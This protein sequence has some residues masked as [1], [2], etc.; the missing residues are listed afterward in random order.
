MKQRKRIEWTRLENV[1]KYF[2]ATASYKDTKVFRFTCELYEAVEPNILQEALDITIENFP[3]YKSVLRRGVFW[4]YLESSDIRP[5][6]EIESKPVCAPIYIKDNRSLLF[7][8]F[9]YNNR[10][11]LEMFHVLSDG[12]GALWFMESLVHYYLVIKYKEK[13]KNNEPELNYSAAISEKMD[14]SF[15]RYFVGEDILK[16]KPRGKNKNKTNPAYQIKGTIMDENRMN[17]IE[18][19]MSAKAVLELAHEYNAT[20]T[21]FLTSLFLFSIYKDMPARRR[22][23]P[24]V[25]SVPINLRQFFKSSTSRNFFSTMNIGYDFGKDNVEF[26]SVIEC[27]RGSFKKELSEERLTRQLNQFIALEKNPFTRIVPLPLKDYVI[28]IA[29]K[30]IDRGVTG[31]LSNIGRISMPPEYDAYIKQFSVCTSAS[32]PKACIC[33]YKDRLVVSF[34]SPFRDTDIQRTFFQ[35]LSKRGIEIEISSNL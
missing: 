35:F 27:V 25:L 5:L 4:Y 14:D 18:G 2:P 34:T 32:K 7:R 20:L 33:S 13:F 26:N 24:V 12:T 16:I 30:I 15:G 29:N 9:Y 11:N 31:S 22:N 10:I 28:R 1:S 8:V 19:S 21:I 6:V 23:R 17:L 3:L